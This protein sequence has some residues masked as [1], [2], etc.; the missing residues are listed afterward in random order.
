MMV[1][2]SEKKD[3]KKWKEQTNNDTKG[4]NQVISIHGD[5]YSPRWFRSPGVFMKRITFQEIQA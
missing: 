3:V 2:G 5:C 4:S 1:I